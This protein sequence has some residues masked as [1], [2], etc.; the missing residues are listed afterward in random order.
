[1]PSTQSLTHY[2]GV[3]QTASKKDGRISYHRACGEESRP[4]YARCLA[5]VRDDA[6]GVGRDIRGTIQG[7]EPAQ[8]QAAYNIN[9]AGGAGQVVALV[10]AFDNPNAANDLAVYRAQWGLPACG[11][12]CF[13]KVN[14]LGQ[15]YNYP[16]PD[17][18]WGVEEDLDIEMVSATCPNCKIILVEANSSYFSDLGAAVVE[19]AALGAT[20]ISNSYQGGEFQGEDDDTPYQQAVPVLASA[21]DDGY[22]TGYPAASQYVI[23]V[24]GTSLYQ[25]GGGS[26]GWTERVWSGSGSGCTQYAAKP[27]WQTDSGCKNRTMNDIAWD[28]DPNTG[29]A[30]YDSYGEGGWFTVGGT[31]VSSPAVAGE[32][33]AASTNGLTNAGFIYAN[34]S[35]HPPVHVVRGGSNE[36]TAQQ[37]NMTDIKIGGNG[38]CNPSYLCQ[39]GPGYDGPSGVGTPYGMGAI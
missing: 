32:I 3:P 26:R 17:S 10:D 9:T 38:G 22:G 24:G 37:T 34:Y 4:R 33:A 29:P 11:S 35:Y 31:S 23:S 15:T 36:R 2:S 7:I 30:E 19:A 27:S 39:A 14:Q 20:V 13:T 1:M 12:G 16:S 8:F 28:A 18:G 21:G 25:G 5:L 6:G